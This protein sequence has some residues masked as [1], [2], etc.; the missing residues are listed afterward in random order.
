MWDRL[1]VVLIWTLV[2]A[3]IAICTFFV[4]CHVPLA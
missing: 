3:F 1:Y 2:L 4:S